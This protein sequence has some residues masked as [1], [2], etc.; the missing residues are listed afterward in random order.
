M[1]DLLT[2]QIDNGPQKLTAAINDQSNTIELEADMAEVA[3]KGTFKPI[4]DKCEGC[5][6]IV[7]ND[8]VQY[9]KTYANPEA[10]WRLGICNFATHQKPEIKVAEVRINPLKA[11]KRAS[12][13]NS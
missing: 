8:G 9:C 3:V 13:R 7:E 12:K 2:G 10:K 1:F 4:I 11:S 6:R 5:E